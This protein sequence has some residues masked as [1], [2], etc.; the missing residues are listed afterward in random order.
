M[1]TT[2]SKTPSIQE[3]QMATIQAAAKQFMISPNFFKKKQIS[4]FKFAHSVDPL[5]AKNWSK[6]IEDQEDGDEIQVPKNIQ[7]LIERNIRTMS[8][9]LSTVKSNALSAAALEAQY[10]EEVK[11]GAL[12]KAL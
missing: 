2:L 5:N 11:L 12:N 1:N 7:E 4:R 10:Q 6:Q 3:M 9:S 8:N